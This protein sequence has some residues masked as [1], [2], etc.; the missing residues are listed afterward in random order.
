M[1]VVEQKSKEGKKGG[2][3]QKSYA[4]WVSLC[5]GNKSKQEYL[6]GAHVF[7]YITTI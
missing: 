3:D 7:S 5:N 1:D 4:M 2:K 6:Y